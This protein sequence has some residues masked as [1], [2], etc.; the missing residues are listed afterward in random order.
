MSDKSDKIEVRITTTDGEEVA[1]KLTLGVAAALEKEFGSVE[2]W[3]QEM[4]RAPVHTA[5]RV[6]RVL[7]GWN[8]QQAK[9]KLSPGCVADFLRDTM[10]AYAACLSPE[11]ENAAPLEGSPTLTVVPTPTGG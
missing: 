2:A 9:E 6:A 3:A 7:F 1:A 10:Q 4:G 5:V 8:E 11:I